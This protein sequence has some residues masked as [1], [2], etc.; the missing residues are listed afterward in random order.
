MSRKHT[1]DPA[2]SALAALYEVE[3]LLPPLDRPGG[4]VV[5]LNPILVRAYLRSRPRTTLVRPATPVD[6]IEWGGVRLRWDA[7]PTEA[8]KTCGDGR[9]NNKKGAAK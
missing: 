8:P 3:R 6:R 7:I 4:V 5:N 9:W 1:T 2:R